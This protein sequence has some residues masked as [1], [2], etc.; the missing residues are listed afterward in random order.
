MNFKISGKKLKFLAKQ[1]TLD[2]H[3]IKNQ[4]FKATQIF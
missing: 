4:V 2:Y 3:E 1:N